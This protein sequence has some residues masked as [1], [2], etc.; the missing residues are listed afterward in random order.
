MK[1][2]I[3]GFGSIGRRHMRNLVE[4]GQKDIILYRTKKSTL[5]VDEIDGFPVFYDLDEA[6]AQNPD[7]VIVSNPTSLHLDVAIPAAKKGCSIFMEKPLSHNL[8]RLQEFQ[9]AV[10]EG[11]GK[12]FIGFQFRFHPGLIKIKELLEK[13]AVGKPATV[14]AQWGEYLPN[15]HPWEDYRKSYSAKKSLGGGVV[16]TLCHPLD[17]LRWIFGDIQSVFAMTGQ[18]G[19]LEIEVE[20]SADILLRFD[21]GVAGSVH[22]NYYQIPGTHNL[23]IIGTSGMM[24]WDNA[25]GIV[26]LYNDEL[27]KWENFPPPSGFERNTLFLGEM[28]HFLEVIQGISEPICDLEDGLRIMEL[29]AGIYHS[30]DFDRMV[31]FE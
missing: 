16:L 5:P 10:N 17:Y 12:V 22:L 27:S 20:D 1:F 29:L 2:L 4:L 21:G 8:D 23:E 24:T 28:Q 31:S 18:R 11:G 26:R 6:L 9:T 3:A 30:A 19:D 14:R 7:A 25:D 13:G 15:W